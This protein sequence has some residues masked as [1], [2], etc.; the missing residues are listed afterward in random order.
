LEEEKENINEVE[1]NNNVES[2]LKQLINGSILTKQIIRKHL[3]FILF[4]VGLS[5]IYIYNKYKTDDLV[6]KI[7]KTH[8]EIKKL[9]SKSVSNASELMIIRRESEVKKMVDKKNLG[10]EELKT[11]ATEINYSK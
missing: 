10:L 3:L 11:P 5:M 8:R 6:I 1:N 7:S 2:F 9:R 4:L